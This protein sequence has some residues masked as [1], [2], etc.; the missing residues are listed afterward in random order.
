MKSLWNTWCAS[1]N[2]ILTLCILIKVLVLTP[3]NDA[4]FKYIDHYTCIKD[5]SKEVPPAYIKLPKGLKSHRKHRILYP[6]TGRK[7]KSVNNTKLK[8]TALSFRLN[9]QESVQT[10]W[11]ERALEKQIS[12]N[13]S[14]RLVRS[15][16]IR[17]IR[18]VI[19]K[20]RNMPVTSLHLNNSH[21]RMD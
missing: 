19:I 20:W 15:Y 7:P 18:F 21:Y 4:L 17:H 16:S 14:L 2:S 3:F 1:T 11:P 9:S 5:K 12:L 8:E 13:V 10:H 6:A